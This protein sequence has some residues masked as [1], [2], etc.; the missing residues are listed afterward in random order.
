MPSI[1]V[2]TTVYNHQEFIAACIESVLVQS[3]DDFEMI[4][5]DDGSVD[6]TRKVLAGFHDPRLRVFHVARMGRGKALNYAIARAS[7]HYLAILDSDDLMACN[8][9]R[10]HAAFLDEH[11]SVSFVANRSQVLIDQ[12]GSIIHRKETP[13]ISSECL[14]PMLGRLEVPFCHS[15]VTYRATMLRL[16]GSFDERL[17]CCLD[18]DLYVRMATLGPPTLLPGAG[19][20]KRLHA[21]QYFRCQRP[22]GNFRR[23]MA[24]I[25]VRYRAAAYPGGSY[26]RVLYPILQ[27]GLLPI[28]RLLQ[29]QH[30]WA[31]CRSA[32]FLNCRILG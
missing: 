17:C 10:Q 27:L 24:Q 6:D 12:D 30:Q 31:A 8:R 4:V 1:S 5:V 20:S 15:S 11:L 26:L 28:R 7:G 2:I 19:C 13:E 9:L 18:K 32:P 16:I 22:Y 3:Y 25:L 14:I 21:T 23:L 29:L